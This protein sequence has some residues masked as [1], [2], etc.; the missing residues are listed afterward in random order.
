VGPFEVESILLEHPAVME[1]AVVGIP[2]EKWGEIIKAFIHLKP[3]YPTS[4][5]LSR[6]I[7]EHVGR[8]L[9]PRKCP[10]ELEFL[11]ELPKTTTGKIRRSELKNREIEKRRDRPLSI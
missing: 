10:R 3:N 4:E 8:S 5:G 1:A 7:L 2:D 6:E 9:E 11:E